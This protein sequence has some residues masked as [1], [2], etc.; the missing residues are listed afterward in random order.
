MSSE[1]QQV[2]ELR[3]KIRDELENCGITTIRAILKCFSNLSYYM[4][5]VQKI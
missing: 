2:S 4:I 3:W 1:D 5:N